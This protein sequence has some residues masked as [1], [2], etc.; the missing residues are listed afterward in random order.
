MRIKNSVVRINAEALLRL[1]K[2][3][4]FILLVTLFSSFQEVSADGN[5]VSVFMNVPEWNGKQVCDGGNGATVASINAPSI[6]IS[7]EPNT[8]IPDDFY[9]DYVWERRENNGT[10][11]TVK[12]ANKATLVP[13]LDPGTL[14]N[15][16]PQGRISK[17]TWRL[18]VRSS[19]ETEWFTSE[20]YSVNVIARMNVSHVIKNNGNVYSIDLRVLGGVESKKFQW[21][22]I[23]KGANIPRE[24][25]QVE[26]PNG[27][28]TGIYQVL[29]KDECQ[30]KKYTVEIQELN[31]NK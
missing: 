24:Q 10:W 14:V 29:I 2:S 28:T 9:F 1:N 26:D 27:L 30:E 31:K 3:L 13:A 17:F 7:M 6:S 22:G 19:G 12:E 5:K 20:E 25:K 18:R 16:D 11:Q 21:T 4:Y 8:D 15:A 23:G